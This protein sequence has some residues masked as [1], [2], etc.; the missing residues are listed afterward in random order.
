[1]FSQAYLKDGDPR[2]VRTVIEW[3]ARLGALPLY[4]SIMTRWGLGLVAKEMDWASLDMP[5]LFVTGSRECHL[6]KQPEPGWHVMRG[7]SERG[8]RQSPVLR[9][10]RHQKRYSHRMRPP[11]RSLAPRSQRTPCSLPAL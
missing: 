6:G 4:A 10:A 8:T 7:H 9:L 2:K 5:V 1:M 11:R 3:R